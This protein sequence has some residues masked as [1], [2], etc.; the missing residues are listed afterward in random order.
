M[1]AQTLAANG[2]RVYITGRRAD[3]LE[4]SSRVHGAR[5]TLG[6]N[7][8]QIL[9]LVMDVTNKESIKHAVDQIEAKEGYLNV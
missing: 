7:G 5:D 6:E 1:I 2:A 8:G 3:V 9:P 4:T